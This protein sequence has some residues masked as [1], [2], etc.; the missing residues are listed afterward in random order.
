MTSVLT[1]E[2]LDS[3]Q[4]AAEVP[5]VDYSVF[6]GEREGGHVVSVAFTGMVD[7]EHANYFAKYISLL[8]ELNS[9]DT[10]SEL[11]N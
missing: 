3:M 8:L 1:R 10:T 6:V 2:E 9:V 11:T 7:E 5:G 4:A